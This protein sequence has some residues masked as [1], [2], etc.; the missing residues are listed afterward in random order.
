MKTKHSSS[1]SDLVSRF[2]AWH[3][4]QKRASLGAVAL[5][6]LSA[7]RSLADEN[8]AARLVRAT[9]AAHLTDDEIRDDEQIGA[10]SRLADRDEVAPSP[11][12]GIVGPYLLT[13]AERASLVSVRPQSR[14]V[15]FRQPAPVADLDPADAL[16]AD[17][18][19]APVAPYEGIID[20]SLLSPEELA[21][22][23]EESAQEIAEIERIN[24]RDAAAVDF[25]SDFDFPA[26]V[27]YAPAAPA[28]VRSVAAPAPEVSADEMLRLAVLA[29]PRR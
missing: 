24:A 5:V 11:E 28:N 17:F 12:S 19:P 26:P 4:A 7:S 15:I 20:P 27:D 21:A 22:I 6:S 29:L 18:I 2:N 14:S 8:G 25:R 3:K 23:D 16:P 9:V 10:V 13:P 1:R